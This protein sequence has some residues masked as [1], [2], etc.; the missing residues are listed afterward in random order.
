MM[1]YKYQYARK[2]EQV[3]QEKLI[4]EQQNCKL[5]LNFITQLKSKNR[6]IFCYKLSDYK[7]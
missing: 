4:V 3:G 5:V 7:L 6:V 1:A 2:F